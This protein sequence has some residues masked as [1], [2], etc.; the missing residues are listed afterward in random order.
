MSTGLP[1]A[2]PIAMA[3][4]ELVTIRLFPWHYGHTQIAFRP[5]VQLAGLG[6][7]ILVTFVLFWV[8]EAAVRASLFRER[9]PELLL[10]LAVFGLSLGYG[11]EV[12]DGLD[13]PSPRPGTSRLSSC[14]A[15]GRSRR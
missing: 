10:P 12:I 4:A 5:F 9:R 6:G 2:L 3:L 14:R 15:T 11:A 7:A 8:A 13:R 1:F